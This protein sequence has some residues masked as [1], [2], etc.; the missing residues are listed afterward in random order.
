M[1]RNPYYAGY[2][3]PGSA[4]ELRSTI[5]RYVDAGAP[6]DEVAGLL[7]PHAGYQYS[8]PVTGAAISRIVFK[9]TFDDLYYMG[10][11]T[12]TIKQLAN[13]ID[14]A[15]VKIL[16]SEYKLHQNYPN[17]FNPVTTI[18]FDLLENSHVKLTIYNSLGQ[19]VATLIDKDM[20]VGYKGVIWDASNMPSGTYFYIIKAG[21]YNETKKMVLLK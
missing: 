6:K 10:V 14:D 9:D 16:P 7:V 8:G 15:I 12:D 19:E 1:I 21:E 20:T 18:G 2:F 11:P 3:Y 4:T 13:G 17:P 5:A